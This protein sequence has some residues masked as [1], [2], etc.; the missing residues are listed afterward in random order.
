MHRHHTIPR[1]MGGDDSDENLVYL[2]RE[3]HIKAHEKLYEEHGMDADRRA[4]D[5]L[6]SGGKL[7]TPA[8]KE[9]RKENNSKA[10]KAAH[11]AKT[12]NGFYKK[13]GKLNSER[14]KGTKNTEHSERMKKF[15]AENKQHWWN[16]GKQNTRSAECPGKNY[17]RG[18]IKT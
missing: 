2:T 14:L 9:W 11:V 12:K 15:Y 5:L 6:K 3:E 10:A 1:H 13:L 8:M 16:D 17:I 18:R 4:I 7:N